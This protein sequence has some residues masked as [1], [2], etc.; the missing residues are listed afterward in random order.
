M[1]DRGVALALST[2]FNPGSCYL[3]SLPEVLSWAALRY[4][5]RPPRR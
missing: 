1:I 3:Q 5:M 2:D 4:R